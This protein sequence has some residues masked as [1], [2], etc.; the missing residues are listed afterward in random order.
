MG[1]KLG[2]WCS[3]IKARRGKVQFRCGIRWLCGPASGKPDP[4]HRFIGQRHWEK[5]SLTWYVLG[6]ADDDHNLPV[7][8]ITQSARCLR[9][10]VR[11]CGIRHSVQFFGF[12]HKQVRHHRVHWRWRA[13]KE[14]DKGVRG[15]QDAAK[16]EK[17]SI[18]GSTCLQ[19]DILCQGFLHS[20]TKLTL[21]FLWSCS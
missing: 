3:C 2:R 8:Q 16:P 1:E 5:P 19:H 11:K 18:I 9:R 21:F 20:S 14:A 10:T 4:D 6:P 17:S 15:A 12:S 13:K 7:S